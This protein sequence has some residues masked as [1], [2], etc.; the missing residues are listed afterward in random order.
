MLQSARSS[1]FRLAQRISEEPVQNASCLYQSV[2]WRKR[3]NTPIAKSK[4]GRVRI[5]T[6]IDPAEYKFTQ[7]KWK[8]YRILLGAIRRHC[9]E[10]LKIKSKETAAGISLEEQSKKEEEEWQRLLAWNDA[11]NAKTLAM[12]E[13]RLKEEARH[14]EAEK[15]DALINMEKED[16]K[17]LAEL[18]EVVRKEKEASKAYITL[19]NLDEAIETALA[20]EKNYSFSIDKSGNVIL[21]E[22]TAWTDLKERLEREENGSNFETETVETNN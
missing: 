19:E 16:A 13:T 17:W 12:R 18:E 10:E 6:P 11:E 9:R 1:V 2:R 15:L 5:P 21:P 3:R 22:D 7:I 4:I 20:D 8:E 14:K